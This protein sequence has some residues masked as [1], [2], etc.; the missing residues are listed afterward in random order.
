MN[1]K[2]QFKRIVAATRDTIAQLRATEEERRLGPKNEA[3]CPDCGSR[4]RVVLLENGRYQLEF[5]EHKV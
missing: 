2:Q 4:L 1:E 5:I 3:Q